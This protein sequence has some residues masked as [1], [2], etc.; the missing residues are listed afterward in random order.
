[1]RFALTGRTAFAS[2][3]FG[4]ERL[5]RLGRLETITETSIIQHIKT[6]EERIERG[7]TEMRDHADERRL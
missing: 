2:E 1:M 7:T 5:I 6:Q 3:E 4:Q